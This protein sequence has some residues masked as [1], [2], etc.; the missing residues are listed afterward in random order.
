VC[1]SG[2]V[3][4]YDFYACT[5]FDSGASQSSVSATFAW[6][7]NLVTEPLSQ[8]LVVALPNGEIVC[9]SK[10]ALGCPLVFGERTLEADL[11]VFK[12]LGFDI[13][14]G[15]DWLHLPVI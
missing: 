5:L 13:I 1:A 4:L 14:L 8:S 12:L 11:I 15:M 7:C 10:V 3:R 2:R 6:M 9:C